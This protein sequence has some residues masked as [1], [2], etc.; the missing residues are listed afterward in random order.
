VRASRTRCGGGGGGGLFICRRNSVLEF[1]LVCRPAGPSVGSGKS[2]CGADSDSMVLFPCA[3]PA[4]T[5]LV[6]LIPRN[7]ALFSSQK[8]VKNST[9]AF[10]FLFDKHC[11]IIE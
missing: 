2:V 3:A 4:R 6:L 1:S 5:P 11:P 7:K 9:V 10:S 8:P